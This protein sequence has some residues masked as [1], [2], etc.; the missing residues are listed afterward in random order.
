MTAVGKSLLEESAVYLGVSSSAF[1]PE[2]WSDYFLIAQRRRS[3][4]P[5]SLWCLSVFPQL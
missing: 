3:F 1:D 4:F 5:S 2:P